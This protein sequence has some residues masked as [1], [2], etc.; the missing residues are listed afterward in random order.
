MIPGLHNPPT[1]SGFTYLP[2]WALTC[3]FRW[4]RTRGARPTCSVS[5]EKVP[6][7]R[8]IPTFEAV[9]EQKGASFARVRT[10]SPR[11]RADKCFQVSGPKVT[12]LNLPARCRARTS[13]S[14]G[15][16]AA[17]ACARRTAHHRAASAPATTNNVCAHAQHSRDTYTFSR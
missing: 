12:N 8:H 2:G 4:E 10:L 1:G 14:A 3:V 16:A 9:L 13:T 5:D 7:K 6:S 15:S 11:L 17:S